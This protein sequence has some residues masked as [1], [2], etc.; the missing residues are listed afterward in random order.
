MFSKLFEMLPDADHLLSLSA[1]ELAGPLL[2]S[3]EGGNQI[4]PKIIIS[5]DDMGAGN[6]QQFAQNPE[7]K[8]S[9]RT[10]YGDTVCINGGLAALGM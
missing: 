7:S 1:E 4:N 6:R 10:A 9:F 2:V 3:L 8:L 5:Y